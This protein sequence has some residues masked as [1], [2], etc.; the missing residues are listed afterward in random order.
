MKTENHSIHELLAMN[1]TSFFIPPFQRSYAWGETELKRYFYDVKKIVLSLIDKNQIEKQE[2]FFGTLVLKNEMEGM[3]SRSIIIDGQQ[4]ITTT[5][6]FLTALRD[7][8]EN[9]SEQ[10]QIEN[11]YL[12]NESSSFADK[13]KLKQVSHDWDAYKA[14]INKTTIYSSLIKKAYDIFKKLLSETKNELPEISV[15]DYVQALSKMNVALIYLD[16]QSYKGEDPQIIFETLNSLGK[17]LTLADLVRNFVLLH[18]KSNEQ[19]EVYE[20]HWYPKIEKVL[21]EETSKFFRDYLQMKKAKSLNV[22]SDANTKELYQEFVSFVDSEFPNDDKRKKFLADIIPFVNLYTWIIFEENNDEISSDKKID[23]I[24]KELL[25]NI[26]HDIKTESFKPFCLALLKGFIDKKIT[27]EILIE[28]LKTIRTYLIRRRVLGL[29]QAENKNVPLL[30][31]Q[32]SDIENCSKSMLDILTKLFY[33]LRFPNDDEVA[34]FLREANFYES[35]KSYAKFILGKIEEHSTKVSVDFRESEI[36]IE[37]IMPQTLNDVWKKELG[38]NFS[39]V[40]QT[41]LHNIGNLILTEFNSEMGNKSFAQKKQKLLESTLHYRLDIIS[42]NVW[43]EESILRHQQK[44]IQAF[45]ETFPLREDFKHRDNYNTNIIETEIFSPLEIDEDERK[46]LTGTK[47][48]D[49]RIGKKHFEV[50]SWQDVF[51][52]M[53]KYIISVKSENFS[54]LCEN[55]KI[56][57]GRDDVFITHDKMN[58]LVK[59]D[60]NTKGKYKMLDAENFPSLILSENVPSYVHTNCSTIAILKRV[61]Q[62]LKEFSFDASDVE[63]TITNR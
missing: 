51:I 8:S 35:V 59:K 44:M 41:Y 14:L 37:H 33:K 10:T 43:N 1:A 46:E 62:V 26:F 61:S 39:Y 16:A 57:F 23:S 31:K 54:E 52:E 17:P 12:R 47:P 50:K 28:T 21:G 40:H 56:L 2:H 4:R 60:A 11:R 15:Q 24:I 29:A 49:L 3:A 27:N 42:E 55:Q 58:S 30:V 34:K 6:I 19:T 20:N 9:V 48:T 22:V 18:L 36:T 38:E 63:I 13:I 5:L 25:C 32:I 7:S 45:L 53:L